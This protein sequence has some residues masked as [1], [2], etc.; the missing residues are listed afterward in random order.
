MAIHKGSRSCPH[1][2]QGTADPLGGSGMPTAVAGPCALGSAGP[3]TAIF[4]QSATPAGEL[5][6]IIKLEVLHVQQ[7]SPCLLFRTQAAP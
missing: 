7:Q 5:F 4:T 1:L 6:E 3:G 2:T